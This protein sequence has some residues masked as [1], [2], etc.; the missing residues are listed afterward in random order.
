MPVGP[1]VVTRDEFVLSIICFMEK[2]EYEHPD[3]QRAKLIAEEHLAQGSSAEDDANLLAAHPELSALIENYLRAGRLLQAARKNDSGIEFVHAGEPCTIK[4]EKRSS[5]ETLKFISTVR[6]PECHTAVKSS[7][8]SESA[9]CPSCGR[10][11]HLMPGESSTARFQVQSQVG[12]FVLMEEVGAGG[13]GI[14]WKA[15]DPQLDR[16]VA[17]K[18]P[19]QA[20][21]AQEVDQFI[22]EARTASRVRHK[23]IVAVHEVGRDGDAVYLVSDFIDGE[24]LGRRMARTPFDAREAAEIVETICLALQAIH[25]DGIVHR[26]LKPDNVLLNKEGI[27]FLTDFGLAKHAEGLTLTVDGLLMGTPAYMSPEQARGESNKADTRSDIYSIGVMI[28]ELLTSEKPFRGSPMRIA[29]QILHDEPPRLRTLQPTIP[30]DLETICL[31]CLEKSPEQRFQ[32]ASELAAEL[33]RFLDGHAIRSRPVSLLERSYRWCKRKPFAA[34]LGIVL[35]AVAFLAS[36][37]SVKFN[38]IA[39]KANQVADEKAHLAYIYQMKDIGQAI[40]SHDYRQARTLLDK[41]IP[42]PGDADPRGFEWYYWQDQLTQHCIWERN[43]VPGIEA[44]AFSDDGEWVA[45]TSREGYALV[46]HMPTGKSFR[47]ESADAGAQDSGRVYAIAF[48]PKTKH[49]AVATTWQDTPSSIAIWDV[50]KQAKLV[51]K[52]TIQSGWIRDLAFSHNGQTLAIGFQD[53]PVEMWKGISNDIEEQIIQTG[54]L[55]SSKSIAFSPDDTELLVVGGVYGNRTLDSDTWLQILD[56]K[57][58]AA[59]SWHKVPMRAAKLG[60]SGCYDGPL[61]FVMPDGQS[62]R[63]FS[64]ERLERE[65]FESGTEICAT[66]LATIITNVAMS[67]DGRLIVFGATDGR[68]QVWDREERRLHI[69]SGHDAD[70][71]D[72]E[73]VPNSHRFATCSMDGFV[74]MWGMLDDS[75]SIGQRVIQIPDV[76]LKYVRN[77]RF[78][79]NDT[80]VALALQPNKLDHQYSL[81]AFDISSGAMRWSAKDG[82]VPMNDDLVFLLE[83]GRPKVVL[84]AH[85]G[86]VIRHWDITSG[87]LANTSGLSAGLVEDDVFAKPL[88]VT[89]NGHQLAFGMCSLVSSNSD[90]LQVVV[91]DLKTGSSKIAFSAHKRQVVRGRW[92]SNDQLITIGRDKFIRHWHI[93]N[94]SSL[95]TEH[96]LGD[97][98]PLAIHVAKRDNLVSVIDDSGGVYFYDSYSGVLTGR[99]VLGFGLAKLPAESPDGSTVAI[100]IGPNRP[101]LLP[102]DEGTHSQVVLYDDKTWEVKAV[103]EPHMPARLNSAAFSPDGTMIA[104]G[105]LDGRIHI[106]HAPRPARRI[107]SGDSREGVYE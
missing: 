97:R 33:R 80:L 8:V 83:N 6:C 91:K 71:L 35:L 101:D 59:K 76:T 85:R 13:F 92:L 95:V 89:P 23:N 53:G 73:F 19:R 67:S 56:V 90:Q 17:L 30:V 66:Q 81:Y 43:D 46:E 102:T 41:Q 107:D 21:D 24:S 7:V 55:E 82:S 47:A 4:Q 60:W 64:V 68:V 50:E 49:L 39:N 84:T 96:R 58:G 5:S 77:L 26:D 32:S 42:K 2:P 105:D 9:T 37:L 12:R 86:G 18:I 40:S 74:R 88:A 44:V 75:P 104:V 1:I 36:V 10:E 63:R 48:M 69:L 72:I 28:F 87:Q 22:R 94:S 103:L 11:I 65:T 20:F 100:P 62:I 14:V 79:D 34:A 99:R 57:S 31:K 98:V 38:S 70:I 78:V 54:G 15:R 27:P 93:A 106:W 45:I 52:T 25:D 3:R 61:H 16:I 29:S 51:E